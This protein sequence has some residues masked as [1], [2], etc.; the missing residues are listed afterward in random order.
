MR[1]HFAAWTDLKAEDGVLV[2]M[3]GGVD[4]AVAAYLLRQTGVR[5][6]GLTMKNYCY[7]D[8]E[9]PDR[10]CC[11]VEAVNDA[12]RECD[13]LGIPHVVADA[14]ELFT[15][16]VIDNFLS[17]YESARTPNP[18][19][20]CNSIVRFQTLLDYADRLGLAHVAT[21]HYARIFEA[22]SGECYLAR[23]SNREKDQSYFLSSVRRD[24]LNRVVF[25]LGDHSKGAVR[26]IA[27]SASMDVA[28]KKESQ[29]VCFVPDG[30]L[31]SFLASRGVSLS[32]GRI[33]SVNG[34]VLGTHDGLAAYTVG[35]R[36]HLGIAT[37]APQYVVALDRE[38][39][40]LVVGD[41][42]AL[43]IGKAM[44][45]LAWIDDDAIRDPSGV[46]AQIRYR[47]E[48]A[49]LRELSVE[50]SRCRVV[51]VDPQRAVCPGQTIAFYRGELVVGSGVIDGV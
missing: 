30:T 6:V 21:G 43:Q 14:E 11:S 42:E 18:C 49:P 1:G 32:P 3:S 17:E 34:D 24:L 38:R 16:E 50:G 36:R 44:C 20:R 5:T 4:S 19:V 22:D 47:H 41:A 37:G 8:A 31:R 9:V 39:N 7:G 23:S 2:A 28:M 25:P 35:Q 33:E 48:G 45:R 26:E 27:G 51:F 40:V 10:S 13:R 46:T 15:H 29:E 12:R